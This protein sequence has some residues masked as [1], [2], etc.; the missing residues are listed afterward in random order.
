MS[1]REASQPNNI[2]EPGQAFSCSNNRQFQTSSLLPL[3][4]LNVGEPALRKMENRIIV[5][6]LLFAIAAVEVGGIKVREDFYI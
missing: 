5:F 3:A 4:A 1:V 2:K 6:L